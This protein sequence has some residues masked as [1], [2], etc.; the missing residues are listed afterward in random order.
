MRMCL[1][2]SLDNVLLLE[3]VFKIMYYCK[4][5]FLFP[6]YCMLLASHREDKKK[7]ISSAESVC[8]R[9]ACC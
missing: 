4:D 6:A 3:C 5:V 1:N 9:K 2:S 7:N 8:L